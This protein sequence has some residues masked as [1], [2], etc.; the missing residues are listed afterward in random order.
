[1]EKLAAIV[2]LAEAKD[3]AKAGALLTAKLA[4]GFE[5]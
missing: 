4:L 3:I 1:M 5:R 2:A